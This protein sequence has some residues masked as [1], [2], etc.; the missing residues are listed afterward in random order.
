MCLLPMKAR[1]VHHQRRLFCELEVRYRLSNVACATFPAKIKLV[2]RLW[3]F[4]IK[5]LFRPSH[6]PGKAKAGRCAVKISQPKR[7][8][9]M[10]KWMMTL[11]ISIDTKRGNPHR[12]FLVLLPPP[13]TR[14]PVA[15]IGVLLH[16]INPPC[17]IYIITHLQ[18]SRPPLP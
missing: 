16:I 3:L 6:V 4:L 5:S 7:R 1:E 10:R 14:P 12:L 2:D 17:S 8:R 18:M 11:L 9:H 15:T 13:H